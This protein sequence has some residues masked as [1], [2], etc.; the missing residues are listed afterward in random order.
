MRWVIAVVL[1][2]GGAGA[3]AAASA[4]N[5]PP[6]HAQNLG[7]QDESPTAEVERAEE[8][9][10][11]DEDAPT[12][13]EG[14]GAVVRT[15]AHCAPRG[16]TGL[17]EGTTHG[18]FVRAAAQGMT[19]DGFDLST[20][21]GAEALCAA[22]AERAAADTEVATR[23]NSNGR[24]NGHHSDGTDEAD[25]ADDDEADESD[26]ADDDAGEAHEADEADDDADEAHEADEAGEADEGGAAGSSHGRGYG[27]DPE[28][29]G[30]GHGHSGGDDGEEAE[31]E[32]D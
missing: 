20:V 23:G 29:R 12:A 16:H 30:N 24:G 3:A 21:E 19:I 15:V 22:L 11:G 25:E 14:H 32:S 26:E 9:A 5:A 7:A 31:P 4:G 1:A 17:P 28:H 6:V 8:P 2:L 27:H 18:S 13:A 10:E